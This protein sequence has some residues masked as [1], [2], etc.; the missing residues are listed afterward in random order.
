MLNI[1]IISEIDDYYM[2][3]YRWN[4]LTSY[5]IKIYKSDDDNETNEQP[6]IYHIV[7]YILLKNLPSLN[8][9][10]KTET[11]IQIDSNIEYDD[12][13]IRKRSNKRSNKTINNT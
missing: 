6:P 4:N 9:R 8:P 1:K 13:F 3:N 5:E 2:I 7:R 11:F 10:I 12:K